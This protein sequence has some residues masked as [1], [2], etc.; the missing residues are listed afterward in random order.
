MNNKFYFSYSKYILYND[1]PLKYKFKYILKYP[2]QNKSCFVYGSAIHK[3]LKEYFTIYPFMN[4][5]QSKEVF[6]NIWEEAKKSA[7]DIKD[8][9]EREMYNKCL[10]AIKTIV[11]NKDIKVKDI[12][13]LQLE[14]TLWID[15]KD[16]ICINMIVDRIEDID[17]NL[18]I[19]DYKTGKSVNTDLQ[20]V[21]YTI[22]LE[23]YKP[24]KNKKIAKIGYYNVDT[25][26]LSF[27]DIP[28]LEYKQIVLSQIDK[29]IS[30][31]K[32]EKFNKKINKFCRWCDYKLLCENVK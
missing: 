10:T 27:K 25:N 13:N 19:I 22:F 31:I 20:L 18:T 23:K 12:K 14:Q 21:F 1:C 16:D 29:T 11:E 30:D 9:D 6:K 5:E 32:S 15:Y 8:F 2:E 26:E 24:L 4:F 17:N 3:F 7:F 28:S